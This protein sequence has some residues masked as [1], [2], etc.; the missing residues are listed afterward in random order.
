MNQVEMLVHK[1][2]ENIEVAE[3]LMQ[4][5]HFD[6]SVSRA[7][8]AMFYLAEALLFSKGMTFSSHSAVIAAFGREFTKTKLFAPKH[9]R[10]LRDGFET[11]QIG[12]YNFET[13]ISKEKAAQILKG[14]KDFFTA[15]NE[16]LAAQ[17]TT[18]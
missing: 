12:D 14:A 7:Y 17:D 18:P 13:N 8:Y 11:R 5:G 4:L 6:I 9:H 15:T 2:N 16:Y 3:M 10:S 1:A